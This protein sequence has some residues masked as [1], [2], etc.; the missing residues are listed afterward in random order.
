MPDPEHNPETEP[1]AQS[2]TD[3]VG[4]GSAQPARAPA[5]KPEDQETFFDPA[6]VSPELMP[7]Y[8]SMQAAF[9]QKNRGMAAIRKS[10]DLMNQALTDPSFAMEMAK[11]VAA[12]HGRTDLLGPQAKAEAQDEELTDEVLQDRTKFKTFLDSRVKKETQASRDEFS[13]ENRR[14]RE[15]IQRLEMG[16]SRDK[17][18]LSAEFETE[19]QD[20]MNNHGLPYEKAYNMVTADAREELAVRRAKAER[21]KEADEADQDETLGHGL[22]A[23]TAEGLSLPKGASMADIDKAL[24]AKARA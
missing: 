15:T 4:G 21:R 18:P 13:A 9:Q 6:K 12:H 14:L 3:D 1:S 22:P 10:A 2:A 11:K 19:I 20:A 24:M 16:M 17:F 23:G 7:A 5:P 8:K